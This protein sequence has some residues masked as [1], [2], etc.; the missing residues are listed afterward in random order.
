[1]MQMYA[2]MPINHS[3]RVWMAIVHHCSSFSYDGCKLMSRK[4]GPVDDTCAGL[5]RS[6]NWLIMCSDENSA[7]LGSLFGV[8]MQF[9]QPA[10]SAPLECRMAC[11]TGAHNA[12]A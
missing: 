9:T 12:E 10:M 1:M 8:L 3:H 5:G 7:L 6:V 2:A 4:A 11:L